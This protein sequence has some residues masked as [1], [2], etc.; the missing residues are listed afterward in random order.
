M[1]RK[2]DNFA[3]KIS[4]LHIKANVLYIEIALYLTNHGSGNCKTYCM[5][6]ISPSFKN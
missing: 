6:H 4:I 5:G 3:S 2:I 1:D